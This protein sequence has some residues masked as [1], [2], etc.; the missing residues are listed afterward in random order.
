MTLG[1]DAIA[2]LVCLAISIWLLVLTIH[3]P[4]AVMV[5]LGPAVY[6]RIV[7]GI[8]AGLSLILIIGDLVAGGRLGRAAPAVPMATQAR[9]ATA[10]RT[11]EAAASAESAQP[12]RLERPNYP[13]VLATFVLF[14]A[15]VLLLPFLGFRFA[16]FLFVGALQPTLEWPRSPLRWLLVLVIA[17]ATTLVCFYIFED[18]L[19]VLLPR[20]RWTGM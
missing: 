18:Y 12:P 16:T 9:E 20:G 8:M 17:I 6:P 10:A 13:L 4:P 19:A 14:G 1:R 11:A 2:G 7:L 5:P 3:L 15:Y